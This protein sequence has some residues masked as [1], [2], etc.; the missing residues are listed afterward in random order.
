MKHPKTPKGWRKMRAGEK[1]QEGDWCSPDTRYCDY[2][3]CSATIGVKVT[4]YSF[5][6]IRRTTA[7][8][9][10][11]PNKAKGANVVLD[12]LKWKLPRVNTTGI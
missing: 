6:Y 3:P 5:T 11:N 12:S 4:L 1:A 8:A 9:G 2:L 10:S 7:R